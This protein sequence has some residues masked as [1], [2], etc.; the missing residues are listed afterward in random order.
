MI[1][2]PASTYQMGRFGVAQPVHTVNLDAFSIGKYE[3]TQ[4]EYEALMGYNPS[5]FDGDYK[6]VECVSWSDALAYCNQL[7]I[8]EGLTPCYDLSDWSCNWTAN[9]YRL[10]TEAEWEYAARGATNTPDYLYA[11]SDIVDDVA[12]YGGNNSPSGTK[13]VGQLQPNGI[14]TFDMSGNV[15]EW[16]WDWYSTNYYYSSP[17]D[18]PTGP[19]S[20]SGR[21]VRGGGWYHNASPC[22]VA[23]RSHYTLSDS[24]HHIGFRLCRTAE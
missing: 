3:V 21:V 13:V 8:N 11:G 16:C 6:P 18:N 4:V 22:Q 7:S 24:L 9:G 14:G 20:G 2:V 12:W 15:W 1:P 23:H 17:L 10:P 19:T 5:C